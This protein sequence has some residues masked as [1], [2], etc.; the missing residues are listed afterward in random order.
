M[1]AAGDWLAL[2][3]AAA[4]SEPRAM[5]LRAVASRDIEGEVEVGVEA[6]PWTPPA[7]SSFCVSGTLPFTWANGY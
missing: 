6:Q 3:E 4:T 7:L 5:G 2:E 1:P